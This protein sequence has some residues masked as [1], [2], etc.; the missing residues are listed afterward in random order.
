MTQFLVLCAIIIGVIAILRVLN[1]DARITN[2]IAIVGVVIIAV[3][4]IRLL[5]PMAGLG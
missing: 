2:I 5:L 4:A 1:F 3:L